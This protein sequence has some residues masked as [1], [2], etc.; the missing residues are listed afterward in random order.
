MSKKRFFVKKY[1]FFR[2]LTETVNGNDRAVAQLL[3]QMVQGMRK[4]KK[5]IVKL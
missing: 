4:L 5:K 2:T 1:G 3:A